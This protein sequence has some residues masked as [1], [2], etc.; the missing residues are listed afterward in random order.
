MDFSSVQVRPASVEYSRSALPFQVDENLV[1]TIWFG[2]AGLT[3]MLGSL[4]PPLLAAAVASMT[5]APETLRCLTGARDIVP[6]NTV[7]SGGLLLT[8]WYGLG[9]GAM[10]APAKAGEAAV[11]EITPAAATMT[12]MRRPATVVRWVRT[13]L[14]AHA[15]TLAMFFICFAPLANCPVGRSPD[16]RNY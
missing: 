9:G 2:L 8:R 3:A 13:D 16:L 4:P 14:R 7:R 11:P 10:D 5:N 1:I 15:S 12:A 6:A